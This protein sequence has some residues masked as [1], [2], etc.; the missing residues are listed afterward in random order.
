MIKTIYSIPGLEV[1]RILIFMVAGAMTWWTHGMTKGGAMTNKEATACRDLL[2][3][4]IRNAEKALG[5]V[6]TVT[7]TVRRDGDRT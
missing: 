1:T 5:V 7:N 2:E 4:L 3:V 6:I